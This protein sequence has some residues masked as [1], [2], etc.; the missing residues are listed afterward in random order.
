M[1]RL[2]SA[3]SVATWIGLLVGSTVALRQPRSDATL[4]GILLLVSIVAVIL[5]SVTLVRNRPFLVGLSFFI[6]VLGLLPG[7]WG[8]GLLFYCIALTFGSSMSGATFSQW[9]FA[10]NNAIM[11]ALPINWASLWRDC[12]H[13]VRL[14][15]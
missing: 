10:I 2:I 15:I 8:I 6:S 4:F 11:I 13:D 1:L 9:F 7:L 14:N 5:Y 12:R 3:L